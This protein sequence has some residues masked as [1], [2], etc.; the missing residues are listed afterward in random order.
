MASMWRTVMAACLLLPAVWTPVA[1]PAAGGSGAIV[2]DTEA[3]TL[4]RQGLR[5]ERGDGAEQDWD[6]ARAYYERAIDAGDSDALWRLGRLLVFDHG[7]PFD[8][9]GAGRE[10]LVRGAEAGDAR[11]AWDLALIHF[12][13]RDVERNPAR[14]AAWARRA[15]PEIPRAAMMLAE[16]HERG[17][18]VERDLSAARE[19]AATASAGG[20]G[21]G[22][23]MLGRMQ[24]LGIGGNADPRA[25]IAS[26]ERAHR[27]GSEQ[28]TRMLARALSDGRHLEPDFA[29]ARSILAGAAQRGDPNA[30]L[31][32]ARWL[33]TWN[34]DGPEIAEAWFWVRVAEPYRGAIGAEWDALWQEL[35]AALVDRLDAGARE[36]IRARAA[37]WQ[38]GTPATIDERADPD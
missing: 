35:D 28:A 1:V 32:L 34:P 6:M 9:P 24:L 31:A 20:L 10:L 5:H 13:G 21:A 14:A 38:P 26:L 18:G 33:V 37:E 27:L 8:E 4:T 36:T 7:D 16:L 23:L 29:R 25:A 11:A 2:V 30:Q 19:H 3:G 22:A 12:E 17:D 15:A